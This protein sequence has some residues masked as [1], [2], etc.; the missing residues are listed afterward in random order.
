MFALAAASCHKGG[1]TEAPPADDTCFGARCVEEAEAAMYYRDYET[2][3]EPLTAVCD[4]GDGF[5]C[6][7]LAELW[8]QGRG[9][10]ADLTKAA[11]YYEASCAGD[12][13]EGCERRSDLAREGDGDPAVELEFAIKA[14]KGG[15]PLACNRAGEQLNAARGVERDEEQAIMMFQA[16]CRLGDADGCNSA[17]KLLVAQNSH[18]AKSRGLAAFVS[19]CT[20]HNAHGCLQVGIAFHNGV[21]TKPDIERARQH[22]VR[23]CEWAEKE[24]CNLEKQLAEADGKPVELQFTTAAP[25]LASGGL[26]AKNISCRM[27]EQ[28][29]PALN[30][31]MSG[32]ARHKQSLDRCAEKGVAVAVTWEFEKG[33]VHEVKAHRLP[34]KMANCVAWTLRKA[35]LTGTGTCEAMLLL[36]DA[37]GATKSLERTE[38]R[39]EAKAKAKAKRVKH[40]NASELE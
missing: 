9:G 17:G 25:E 21:G 26:Q 8:H 40:I 3:R 20:G 19:A 22:F 29:P 6:F 28:G 36:G 1:S 16:A 11:Q 32:V 4:K 33:R 39:V 5:Q 10:P 38:A 31:V 34:K 15:R 27:T 23:A 30:D 37:D 24:G 2:A 12:Y 18:E 7:R 35:R 14:C 13:A